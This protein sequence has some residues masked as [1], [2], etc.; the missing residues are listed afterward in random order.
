MGDIRPYYKLYGTVVKVMFPLK[1][2]KSNI[3]EM[4]M[5]VIQTH[6]MFELNTFC[7]N[8][9]RQLDVLMYNCAIHVS[10]DDTQ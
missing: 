1:K 6:C 8:Q 4:S 2:K 9:T 5:F 7:L 10:L 3:R